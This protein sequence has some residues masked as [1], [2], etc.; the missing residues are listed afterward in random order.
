MQIL[1][2]D[3][4]KSEIGGGHFVLARLANYFSKHSDYGI[5]PIVLLNDI[6]NFRERFLNKDV[7]YI[8]FKLGSTILSL[9]RGQGFVSF[10]KVVISLGYNLFPIWLR[11]VKILKDSK[12]D[13]VHANS[14][15]AFFVLSFPARL[16]RVTLIYHLHDT[17]L[18]PKEGGTMSD[19]AKN[20]LLF[21][22]KAFADRII[23]VSEFAGN[24]ITSKKQPLEKKISI[25]HNGL[26]LIKIR[27]SCHKVYNGGLPLLVA[28]GRLDSKKGFHVAIAAAAILRDRYGYHVKLNIIGDGSMRPELQ[29]MVKR[30]KLNGQVEMLGFKD[31]VHE[32]VAQGDIVLIP[33]V[34]EDPL[35][36][37]VIEAMANS[38]IIIASEVGGIPEMLKN[39]EEGFLVP[40]ADPEAIAEKVVWIMEHPDKANEIAEKAYERVCR[41]FTIERMAFQL[42]NIYHSVIERNL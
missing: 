9:K 27:Q 33:S 26:E 40:K 18:S 15:T 28:F 12:I 39:G 16:C 3:C 37:A 20:M 34:W 38:K 17:L 19:A 25:V 30:E 29:D 41:E 5:Q 42:S 2:A 10:S 22:M 35:P 1:F 31:N 11:L 23:V 14:M 21:W 8:P 24:T 13:L 6:R 4:I 7:K 32:Y 36:L